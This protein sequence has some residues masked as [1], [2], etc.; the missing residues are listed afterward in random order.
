MNKILST[1]CAL[2]FA[3]QFNFLSAQTT[4]MKVWKGGNVTSSISTADIDSVTFG[5]NTQNNVTNLGDGV[6]LINGH[7]FVDLGLP[8]G[9]LWATCNIGAKAATDDGNYYA[10]GETTT[11]D[12]YNWSTYKYG[13]SQYN[14][15]KYDSTDGKTVLENSDDAAYVNWGSSCR[16]PTRTEF[17]E[18]CNKENCTWTWTSRTNSSNET[19]N[20]YEVTSKKNGNSI[21]LPASGYR[22][23]GY[24]YYPGSYGTYWSSS[25]NVDLTS[26]ACRLF[27]SGYI[28][29]GRDSRYFGFTVRPVAEP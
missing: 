26:S 27:C 16:M 3:A 2:L 8:S 19:I 7:K 28:S 17:V 25:L 13:S 12:T 15:T 4:V 21:F 6:Y 11:K 24:L 29:G 23:E 9:L 14:L 10:W 1:T 18:L 20:G 22:G 5:S